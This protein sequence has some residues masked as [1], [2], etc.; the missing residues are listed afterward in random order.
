MSAG[1]GPFS[2]L[3][4]LL[5]GRYLRARRREGAISVIAGFSLVGIML[6]VAT[7]IIVMSVMNGFRAELVNRILG[8]QPHISVI[9]TTGEGVRDFQGLAD[10]LKAQ[11]RVIRAAPTIERQLMAASEAGNQG[12]LLRALSP[13]DLRTLPGVAEPEFAIGDIGRFSE[14]IAIGQGLADKLRVGI[15]D[16][17]TLIYPRGLST[18]G[19]TTPR[20]WRREVTYIFR[21]G[22][23]QYDNAFIFM[24]LADAQKYFRIRERVDAIEIMVDDPDAVEEIGKAIMPVTRSYGY[25]WNWQRSNGAFLAALKVERN[26]MFLILTLIILVAALNI[27]S[28]LIMLV[29]EKGRDIGILRTMGLTRGAILR[30]FFICGASI[31]VVGTALGLLLGVVFTANIQEIQGLVERLSGGSVWDPEVRFLTRV[32]AE[33]QTGD[34]VFTVVIAL[35]LSFLATWYP[36]WRAARLDP[37]EA[38]RYE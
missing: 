1:A 14:G 32:P 25:L 26:V 16:E 3:E 15:G 37:V 27:I 30:V 5:A 23:S 4:W 2:R 22:M 17:L 7:L 24:P 10:R 8:A 6:G 19:G 28:G 20:V 21:I 38:L 29:K 33:M 31:G 9:S 12:A 18:P 35:G 36:A 13:E 34:V 11:P